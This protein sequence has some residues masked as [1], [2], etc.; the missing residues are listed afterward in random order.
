MPNPTFCDFVSP[1]L[2]AEGDSGSTDALA[3]AADCAEF[4]FVLDKADD[5][6]AVENEADLLC[7]DA[8]DDLNTLLERTE[9]C[10][11]D[12]EGCE[13]PVTIGEVHKDSVGVTCAPDV[14]GRGGSCAVEGPNCLI[15]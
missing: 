1:A 7:D 13:L 9:D 11:V 3:V 8:P 5:E 2:L 12:R 14:V 15:R 10:A 4:D 6:I